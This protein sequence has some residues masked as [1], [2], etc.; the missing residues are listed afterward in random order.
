M[1]V[2]SESVVIGEIPETFLDAC[3]NC[4]HW[5]ILKKKHIFNQ[6]YG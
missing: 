6:R 5:F 2:R 3:A 4:K 1:V